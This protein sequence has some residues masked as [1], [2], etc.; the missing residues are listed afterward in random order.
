[1]R[2]QHWML[3]PVEKCSRDSFES[4]NEIFK[5][6]WELV[7]AYGGYAM[8]N[9]FSC[10][11]LLTLFSELESYFWLHSVV[12]FSLHYS[13]LLSLMWYHEGFLQLLP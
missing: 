10:S 2:E 8:W 9:Y 13:S 1:M 12:S 4:R 6:E 5:G 11:K 3:D 7:E